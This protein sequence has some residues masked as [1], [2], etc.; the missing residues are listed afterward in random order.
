MVCTFYPNI[1]I[2]FCIKKYL[3][4]AL[5]LKKKSRYFSWEGSSFTFHTFYKDFNL[6][7]KVFFL[8]LF[9]SLTFLKY[10]NLTLLINNIQIIN[11]KNRCGGQVT[12]LVMSKYRKWRLLVFNSFISYKNMGE[13][14]WET[15]P[16]HR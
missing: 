6:V 12:I 3:C 11:R 1:Y 7:S 14:I 10:F 4:C 13:M 16:T 2:A 5:V 15:M 9:T 8:G